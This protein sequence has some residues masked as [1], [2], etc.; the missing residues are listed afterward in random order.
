MSKQRIDRSPDLKRLRDEGYDIEVRERYL[1]VRSFPYLNSK[2]EV[3]YGTFVSTLQWSGDIANEPDTHAAFFIGDAPCHANGRPMS[4]IITGSG[5]QQLEPGLIVDHSFSAK[6]LEGKYS[7]FY[8]KVKRHAEI[9]CGPAK[10]VDPNATPEVFPVIET[11]ETESVFKY[12]DTASSR[13]G[14]AMATAKLEVGKVGIIGVGG[15]GS[16][17]LDL[18]AKTP[19]KEIHIFDGDIMLNHNAFRS[20]GAPSVEELREKPLK[21][22]Y[23]QKLYSKMRRAIIAH[24]GYVTE[25]NVSELK[26]LDFVF[27]SMD[28]GPAKQFI[29]QKLQEWAV[30]F[31]DVGM[32]L[33]LIKEAIGG[34]L[35]VTVSTKEKMDH[36]LERIPIMVA[37]K[38]N[39]YSRNVQVADLNA[40]NA[41]MA[42]IKWKKLLGF[43]HDFEHEHF[44]AYTLDGN[45]LSNEDRK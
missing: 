18:L 8:E 38:N 30:P 45:R 34:I 42:V 12:A 32:G 43:Y 6:P 37:D 24:P 4:E 41:A 22:E 25:E 36:V 26:Q 14:I 44:S 10:T 39:D 27:L 7:N 5:K 2:G 23:F 9:I 21:A 33:E 19:V 1:L 15:S 17:I 3:F 11:I 35:T 40:L 20:P 28:G 31:I 13:A 16:Y 29:I